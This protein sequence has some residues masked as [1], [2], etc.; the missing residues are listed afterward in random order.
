MSRLRAGESLRVVRA[1]GK[2]SAYL[3]EERWTVSQLI[4]RSLLKRDLISR[5]VRPRTDEISGL[6]RWKKKGERHGNRVS[7]REV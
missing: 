7:S 1:G 6:Y 3:E 2:I 4:F 5:V